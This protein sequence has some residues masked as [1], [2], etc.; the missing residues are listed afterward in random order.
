[1]LHFLGLFVCALYIF[2]VGFCL[3]ENAQRE[4]GLGLVFG[5]VGSKAEACIAVN[6]RHGEVVLYEFLLMGDLVLEDFCD[7]VVKIREDALQALRL[8]HQPCPVLDVVFKRLRNP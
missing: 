4:L 6:P 3:A 2:D 5:H 7:L 8:D 1:M